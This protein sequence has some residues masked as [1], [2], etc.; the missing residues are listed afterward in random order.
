LGLAAAL[1]D[2]PG[3]GVT[4]QSQLVAIEHPELNLHPRLQAEIADVILE[5]ALAEA[6]KGRI[7]F[8]ETHSEIFTLRL[9]RRVRETNRRS[10]GKAAE[11]ATEKGNSANVDGRP[12]M[13]LDLTVMPDD[14]AAWYVDRDEGHV[15]IRRI[16]HDRKGDLIDPWP[17]TIFDQDFYERFA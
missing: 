6:T 16:E 10:I 2:Q 1:D 4:L 17:D 15:A 9:L 13:R 12:G 3:G 7:F 11:E 14:V 5:G 8:I